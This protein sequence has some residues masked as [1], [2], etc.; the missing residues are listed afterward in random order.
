MS[1][2]ILSMA[3][4]EAIAVIW[5]FRQWLQ[6]RENLALLFAIVVLFAIALDAFSN[7]IGRFIGLGETLEWLIRFRMTLFFAA[8][9]LLIAISILFLG[10]AGVGWARRTAVTTAVIVF[11]FLLGAYQI[12]AYGDMALYPSCVFDVVRY[13]LEVRPDQACRPEEAGLGTFDLS[14]VVPVSAMFLLL[15]SIA[16]IWL[17]RF[18]WVTVVFLLS[19][20]ASAISVQIPREGIWTFVSYPFDGLLGF[21]L[22]F[23]AIKLYQRHKQQSRAPSNHSG[24]GE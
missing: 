3:A 15:T 24:P 14:P 5:A 11:A 10:L 6:Q 9:P 7:G 21:L 13:V 8:M 19:N 18:W 17:T 12:V 2:L 4:I 22:C 23:F 16:L 20:I 1:I